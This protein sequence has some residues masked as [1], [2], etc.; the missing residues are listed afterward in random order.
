MCEFKPDKTVAL[1]KEFLSPDLPVVS[2]PA[3]CNFSL[4]D[5]KCKDVSGLCLSGGANIWEGN[6]FFGGQPVCDDFW[7]IKEATLVSAG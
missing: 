4:Q 5:S 6:V 7:T 1:S 2:G 3:E